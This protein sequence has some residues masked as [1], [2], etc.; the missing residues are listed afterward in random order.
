MKRKEVQELS[1]VELH[2]MLDAAFVLA[3]RNLRLVT[4][5]AATGGAF[6]ESN[7]AMDLNIECKHWLGGPLTKVVDI[8]KF[9]MGDRQQVSYAHGHLPLMFVA[10]NC[11]VN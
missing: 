8:T 6:L 3:K 9:Q 4:S 7:D 1:Y 11:E 2:E 5:G 10:R